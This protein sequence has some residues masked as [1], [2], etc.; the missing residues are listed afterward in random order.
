MTKI[1]AHSLVKNE[2][3]Y[4]WYSVTSV[5]DFVDKVLLW[6]T[7]ST[8]LTPK[9]SKELVKTYPDK[10]EY[11]EIGEVTPEGYTEARQEM[12]SRTDADWFLVLDGDEV[13]WEESIKKALELINRYP[14]LDSIVVPMVY[15][16]GDI[17]HFQEESAG[18]YQ[19][20]GKTGHFAVKFINRRI[21]GLYTAKPHGQH[22]YY[23]GSNV[24]IQDRPSS[25]RRFIDRPFLHL[26]HM[27]R[28]SDLSHDRRVSKRS[29]KF[30][31]ELGN[32]FPK[33][34]FYPEVFFRPRP[35]FVPPVW[36]KMDK[37]YFLKAF[38]ESPARKTK[39]R[40]FPAKI[41]Y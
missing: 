3:R 25:G 2:E 26:S 13:W 21:P 39:R 28:S 15:P 1:F 17:Y 6:D 24:L 7:G 37:N 36:K 34:Y 8:D 40:I 27:I 23:D 4:L 10:I 14:N 30:K 38:I 41:G 32:P 35:S 18:K 33:D 16:I 31:Y 12:L 19:I 9:I 20:D 5:I 11:R 29:F 22:G